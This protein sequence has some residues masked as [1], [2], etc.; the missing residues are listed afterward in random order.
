VESIGQPWLEGTL[1]RLNTRE[2]EG[3]RLSSLDLRDLTSLIEAS[4]SESQF[5][6][7]TPPPYQSS[8][9]SNNLSRDGRSLQEHSSG[10]ANKQNPTSMTSGQSDEIEALPEFPGIP[11]RTSSNH[12]KILIS[13]P[14]SDNKQQVGMDRPV[15]MLHVSLTPNSQVPNS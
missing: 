10:S 9:L 13:A 15:D 5:E 14:S 11:E 8:T 12:S 6:D 1:E 3:I 7:V 2:T 4:L